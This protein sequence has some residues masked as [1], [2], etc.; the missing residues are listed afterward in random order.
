MTCKHCKHAHEGISPCT[1]LQRA[2]EVTSEPYDRFDT[3]HTCRVC[4]AFT[5]SVCRNWRRAGMTGESSP[6]LMGS[7]ADMPQRCSGFVR[8]K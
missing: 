7:L 1:K 8:R 2:A 5:G 3:L 6:V 4:A